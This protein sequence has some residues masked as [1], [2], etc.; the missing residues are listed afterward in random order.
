MIYEPYIDISTDLTR[1]AKNDFEKIINYLVLELDYYT[2]MFFFFWK[3][4]S[5]KNGENTDTYE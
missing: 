4:I 3:S 1:K 5:N 2:T